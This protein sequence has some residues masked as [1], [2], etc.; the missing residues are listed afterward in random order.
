MG[1]DKAEV[2]ASGGFANLKIKPWD[3]VWFNAAYGLD[4]PVKDGVV[5]GATGRYENKIFMA[6]IYYQVFSDFL[7]SFETSQLTT[8]YKLTAC[9]DIRQSM[10][11]QASV[12]YTF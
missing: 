1:Y 6:N 10:H 8:K 7:V 9:D 12:K 5:A 2:R 4:K 3:K 11:F